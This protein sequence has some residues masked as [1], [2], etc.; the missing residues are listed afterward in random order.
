MDSQA[1]SYVQKLSKDLRNLSIA[2]RTLLAVGCDRLSQY[3]KLV[4][5][6][7]FAPCAKVCLRG[8]H[9]QSSGVTCPHLEGQHEYDL[10]DR[11]SS[12][13]RQIFH[14][15][16]EEDHSI[17]SVIEDIRR[18]RAEV[19]FDKRA[20]NYCTEADWRLSLSS[21]GFDCSKVLAFSHPADLSILK[22]VLVGS[23]EF[24]LSAQIK[25]HQREQFVLLTRVNPAEE[26]IIEIQ[27]TQVLNTRKALKSGDTQTRTIILRLE[28]SPSDLWLFADLQPWDRSAESHSAC[29][30]YDEFSSPLQSDVF[31]FKLAIRMRNSAVRGVRLRFDVGV[32]PPDPSYPFNQVVKHAVSIADLEELQ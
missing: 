32:C 3:R 29:I 16:V 11:L 27:G 31:Y 13:S 6:A 26:E 8:I 5:D 22:T 4:Q 20:G 18:N 30:C 12:L 2:N 14:R 15:V 28:D 9:I 23:V 10:H 19:L 24:L 17:P 7:S 21:A 1:Q 25:H